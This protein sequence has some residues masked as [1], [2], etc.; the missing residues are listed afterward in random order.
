MAL[1]DD[2]ETDWK[3]VA[4]DINDPLAEKI[5]SIEDVEK[6]R[7]GL[8][9]A[10]HEWFRIYKI[11]T[12][13]PS[14]AFAFNG[15]FKNAD[16]ALRIIDQTHGFWKELMCDRNP[17]LNTLD[18][19]LKKLNLKKSQKHSKEKNRFKKVENF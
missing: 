13:K 5:N 14:N 15:Q 12:G 6:L 18:F 2:G 10:T 8:L 19:Y 17:S 4:I 16:F 1:L 3:L 11:P 9:A 7:P